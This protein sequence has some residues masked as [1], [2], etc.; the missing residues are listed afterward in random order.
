[1][2]GPDSGLQQGT[3]AERFDRLLQL[4]AHVGHLVDPVGNGNGLEEIRIGGF[5]QVHDVSRFPG[6]AV[7]DPEKGYHV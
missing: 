5:Q 6:F 4:R 7:Q 2:A 1:M 3:W